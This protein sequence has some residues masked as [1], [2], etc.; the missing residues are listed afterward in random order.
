M[1][2]GIFVKK[3]YV[4]IKIAADL[5]PLYWHNYFNVIQAEKLHPTK[6]NHCL[7]V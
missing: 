4:T 3:K 2:I 7:G 6:N 1:N 5:H